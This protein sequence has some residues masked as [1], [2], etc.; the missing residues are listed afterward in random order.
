MTVADSLTVQGTRASVGDGMAGRARRRRLIYNEDGDTL[1]GFRTKLHEAPMSV[2]DYLSELFAHL[3]GTHVDTYVWCC[4]ATHGLNLVR[5]DKV[6]PG[7]ERPGAESPALWMEHHRTADGRFLNVHNWRSWC[8]LQSFLQAGHN[9]AELVAR[10]ARD[11]G[12]ELF[13]SLRMNDAH[14][15]HDPDPE[16]VAAGIG[17]IAP[18]KSEHPDWLIGEPGAVYEPKS[19]PWWMRRAFDYAAEGCR[20][21]A[22]GLAEEILGFDND[23]VELDFM[24]HPFLFRLGRERQDAPLLTAMIRRVKALAAERGKSLMVRVPGS[25]ERCERIGIDV[26]TWIREEIV[27]VLSL[28]RSVTPAT[29]PTGAW[30]RAVAGTACQVF[31]SI[32]PNHDP[33]LAQT[34]ALRAFAMLHLR[35]GA[36]GVYLFNFFR[37]PFSKH[38]RQFFDLDRWGWDALREIGDLDTLATRDKRYIFD[39]LKASTPGAYGHGIPEELVDLPL[40]LAGDG[41]QGR[42]RFRIGD[43]LGGVPQEI[44]LRMEVANLT[45]RDELEL[46]VNGHRLVGEERTYPYQYGAEIAFPVSAHVLN[47]GGNELQLTVRKRNPYIHPPLIVEWAEVSIRYR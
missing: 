12:M 5:Q 17:G 36:H 33:R 35:D 34:E 14:D 38:Y 7:T 28:G 26:R 15:A 3:A 2:E 23:G 29:I 13:F 19:I 21:H 47:T 4:G 31:P 32:N 25:I 39:F 37:Q 16:A 40:E 46:A 42:V 24:S 20:D 10:G 18:I 41:Q 30:M 1:G 43:R 22:A 44:A 8:N 27:D 6:G 45:E 11:C 9:P